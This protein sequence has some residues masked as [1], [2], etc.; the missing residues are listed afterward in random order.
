MKK[1]KLD[2][3]SLNKK[4]ISGLN[5]DSLTGGIPTG[6]FNTCT[7]PVSVNGGLTCNRNGTC[8]G[9]GGTVTS[10]TLNATCANGCTV[11]SI[12]LSNCGLTQCLSIQACALQ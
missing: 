11:N 10:P 1:K 2:G 12:Q 7:A 3:L 8:T 9:G 4:T 6:S 5:Q